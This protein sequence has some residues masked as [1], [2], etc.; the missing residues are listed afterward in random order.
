[1]AILQ[2]FLECQGYE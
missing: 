2:S 1:M